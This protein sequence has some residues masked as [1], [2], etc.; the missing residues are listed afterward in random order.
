[1]RKMD[2][3]EKQQS[4]YAIKATYVFS[5]LFEIMYFVFECVKA[6][7]F[8]ADESV[9]FFLFICQGLV[10]AISLS[11]LKSKTGDNRGKIAIVI[12]IVAALIF[13]IAGILLNR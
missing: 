6:N 7:R 8:V 4:L 12:A 2:E 3:M 13:I 1:M 5:L 9:T 11:I 10:L